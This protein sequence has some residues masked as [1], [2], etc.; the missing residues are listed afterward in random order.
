MIGLGKLGLPLASLIASNR[1]HKV[2]GLDVNRDYV[3]SLRSKKVL[4][5][6]EPN[7]DYSKVTFTSDYEELVA[8]TDMSFVCVDTPEDS[9]GGMDL[10][11]IESVANSIKE[12]MDFF[13]NSFSTHPQY[14]LVINSTILP[15]TCRDI[16]KPIVGDRVNVI[17]NPV[18]VALGSVIKDLTS[19]PAL[20]IGDDEEKD[21]NL[22][23]L[24]M[25]LID[26]PMTNVH[27]TDTKSA[28]WFKLAHNAHCVE[29]MAFMGYLTDNAERLGLNID[30]LSRFFQHGGERAG[31]FWR[32]GPPPS[33][34]CF[35]RD[36]RFWNYLTDHPITIAVQ[37]INEQRIFDIV[38]NIPPMSDVLI[39]GTGYKYGIPVTK[40]SLSY[41]LKQGLES[42]SCEVI[43]SDEWEETF[44]PTHCIITHQE[45]R[46]PQSVECEV[47]NLW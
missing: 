27:R 22:L 34:P 3:R 14:T 47:I 30:H 15:G 4:L 35:P 24:W 17:S 11:Q 9:K 26:I 41:I 8:A 23:H 2:F 36:L 1:D 21:M 18:W 6:Y 5:G 13:N 32:P 44:N 20:V 46:V 42:K 19:P 37:D 10:S 31:V 40:G 38:E 16:I 29:K 33:G 7:I 43:V 12:V 25:S 39:L 45:L 28:E